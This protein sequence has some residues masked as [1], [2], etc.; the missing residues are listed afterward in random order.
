MADADNNKIRRAEVATGAVTTL[1]GSGEKGDAD[2]VG[3]TAQ[4][5]TPM[6]VAISPDGSALFVAD[7]VN[8]KIRGWRWQR[9]R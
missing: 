5:H 3:G 6:G 8:Q 4:F 7:L 1:A 2:G 9:A